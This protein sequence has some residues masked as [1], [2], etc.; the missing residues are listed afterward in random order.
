MT[1]LIGAV[2]NIVLDPIF[3]FVFGMGVQGAAL[4]TIL[5]QFLSAVWA[6]SFLRGKKASS[7]SSGPP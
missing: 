4:A 2:T 3:I 5:S 6:V 7:A 1:V